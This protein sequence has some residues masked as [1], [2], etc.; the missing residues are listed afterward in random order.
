MGGELS[1]VPPQSFTFAPERDRLQL[2]TTTEALANAPHFKAN[3]W[4]D[5]N[6]PA[7]V[8]GVYH[9]YHVTPYFDTN[10]AD[11]T[12][13][14]VRDRTGN[15]LTPLDQGNNQADIDTTAH[16]RKDIL[17]RDGLST[18]ARNVKIITLNGHVTLRGP[19]NNA[20]E[21]AA[22]MQIA[23]AIAQPGNVDNQLHMPPT[24]FPPAQTINKQSKHPTKERSQYMSKKSVFCI[25]TSRNQAEIIVDRLKN[26]GFSNNDI[27]V[28]FPDKDTSRDFAHEKNTKAP[29]GIAT[30]AGSGGV[31]GGAL[32]WLAGIGALAIP[33]VGPFIAAG[34]DSRGSQRRGGRRGGRRHC[35]RLDRIGH[36]G[37]GSQ[38]LR[39]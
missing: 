38:T 32:G 8:G 2:D 5:V 12:E 34:P 3:Q 39:R 11:N 10:N 35:R 37:I 27:S 16:I 26:A 31:I 9:S 28:L 25:A 20:D 18:N 1:A 14:N 22:I 13:Q 7:Y 24:Q 30:G 36:S 23:T 21:S 6:D 33:G 17:A 29:E 19:V 4:P 15:T